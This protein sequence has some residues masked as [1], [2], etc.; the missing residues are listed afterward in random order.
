MVPPNIRYGG[1]YLIFGKGESV[2][3]QRIDSK[4]GRLEGEPLTVAENSL[5]TMTAIS[6]NGT[7]SHVPVSTQNSNGDLLEVDRRGE[8]LRSFGP[9]KGYY[10]HPEMSPDGKALA[11]DYRDPVSGQYDIWTIDLARAVPNRLTFPPAHGAVPAWSGDGRRIYF[12]RQE[13]IYSVSATGGGEPQKI[14][15]TGSHHKAASPDGQLLFT[16]VF[17]NTSQ[18]RRIAAV[19]LGQPGK[20]EMFSAEGHDSMNPQVSP[21]GK[22][23]AYDSSEVGGREVFVESIPPGKGKWQIS[24]NGARGPRWR[25]D[26]K[27]LYFADGLT[28]MAVEIGPAPGGAIQPGQP[29]ALFQM[30]TIS[31]SDGYRF[32]VS[33]DGQ[34]FYYV[35]PMNSNVRAAPPAVTI[36]LNWLPQNR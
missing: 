22:W 21:D 13:E 10:S 20:I 31:S 27:E 8:R 11:I 4:T 3:A 24:R 25:R 9:G 12:G 28:L 15:A 19:A 35:A 30:N 29:K 14:A 23:L 7:L 34:R 18:S 2:V 5:T 16:E 17:R 6:D 1:G 32:T 36:T 26:G 33:P